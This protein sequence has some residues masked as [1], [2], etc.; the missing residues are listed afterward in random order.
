MHGDS[1]FYFRCNVNYFL[2]QQEPEHGSSVV[3]LT[4]AADS[5]PQTH[6]APS[7]LALSVQ[8]SLQQQSSGRHEVHTQ[9][10]H[11]QGEVPV[12]VAAESVGKQFVAVEH[13]PPDVATIFWQQDPCENVP[14]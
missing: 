14:M 9:L 4:F 3:L 8:Q 6:A 12:T 10:A 11:S 13:D 2:A 1:R 5:L 7:Q